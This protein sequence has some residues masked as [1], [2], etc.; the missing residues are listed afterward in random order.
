MKNLR[1]AASGIVLILLALAAYRTWS[2]SG[3]TPAVAANET[4]AEPFDAPLFSFVDQDGGHVTNESLR[5]KVWI[6]DFFFTRCTSICPGMTARF[7]LLQ[8]QLARDPVT[9]V[10]FSV[11][12]EH[13]TPAVLAEYARA[14]NPEETRWRLLATTP[15]GLA[16]TANGMRVAVRATGD[17]RDPI[18][19]TNRF[20]LVDA[21]GRVRG[22][23]DSDDDAALGRLRDDARRLASGASAGVASASAERDGKALFVSL[24]CAACHSDA[25]LAPAL[26]GLGG[27]DVQLDGG[28]V[29]VA[30]PAYV[31]ESIVDPWAKLVAGY[32]PTMPS[33]RALL[34][35]RGLRAI[36]EYVLSDAMP[37]RTD[38]PAPRQEIDPVCKMRVAATTGTPSAEFAGRTYFFCCEPCRARFAAHPEGYV[39]SAAPAAAPKSEAKDGSSSDVR[40]SRLRAPSA[41]DEPPPLAAG[42]A[43]PASRAPDG[44]LLARE[45]WRL[46]TPYDEAGEL[47]KFRFTREAYEEAR[48]QEDCESFRL[49][50]ASDGLSIVGFLVQPRASSPSPRPAILFCRGGT[51]DFGAIEP[52][53]LVDFQRWARAGFAVLATNYRGGGGSEGVDTWCG[54]DVD[55]VM[56]LVALAR[57]LGGIDVDRL[58]L[59]GRS[60]G[61]VTAYVALRRG[62]RVRA[63]AVIAGPSDLTTQDMQ[64]AEFIDGDAPEFRAIGWPGWRKLWPDFDVRRDEHL[65][66]RS[67]VAWAQELEVP[68][69]LLHSR[70]DPR[71]PVEHSLRL[72]EELQKAGKEFEL[73]VYSD[74][75]HSL[76]LRWEDRDAHVVGWFR[77]HGAR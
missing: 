75:G 14:W 74:D 7:V 70:A 32:G 68:I 42:E 4:S 71:V 3:T 11:D 13:D 38:A 73:V 61:G 2:S 55:D 26:G 36:V 66:A 41:G 15:D 51:A 12:P 34:D 23:Y 58:Y 25:R 22:S 56:N 21:E 40:S 24:G 6:A 30:D 45:P 10:S 62:L 19:H 9:F 18:F 28:T 48:V 8:A 16:R 17:E 77:A 57:N 53:D 76:P 59:L 35:A 47:T 29:V 43:L 1:W 39:E 31:E 63:A 27:R 5:G 52:D 69:L 60:R 72:A 46:T 37:A 67:A 50:Y 65:R 44:T 54:A 33:Y 49:R 20:L 64:R